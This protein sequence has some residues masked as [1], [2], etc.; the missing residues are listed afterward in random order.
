MIKNNK[1]LDNTPIRGIPVVISYC[2]LGVDIDY[3]KSMT[4]HL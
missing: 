1:K 2:Y 3:L 4:Q